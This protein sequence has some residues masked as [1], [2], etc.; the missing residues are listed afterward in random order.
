MMSGIAF[1]PLTA[2]EGTQ[3]KGPGRKVLA[4]GR[5]TRPKEHEFSYVVGAA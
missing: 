5:T 4:R 2:V 3:G 1:G